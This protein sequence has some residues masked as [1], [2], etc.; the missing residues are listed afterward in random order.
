MADD[1]LLSFSTLAKE[2]YGIVLVTGPTGSGKSTT[3]K[4]TLEHIIDG[5]KKIITVEDPVEYNITGITQVQTK[6]EIGYTFATALRSILRQDPDTIMIGEIR[7]IE[8]AEIAVQASLTGHMVFSTLHTNDSLSAFTRLIDM[9]VEPFLV[10]S[11]IRSVLAQRLARQVCDNCK[12]SFAPAKPIIRKYDILRERF[13]NLTVHS[14]EWASGKGCVSC[15]NTGYKGRM[16]LYEIALVSNEIS[17]LI[18][19]NRP[20]HELMEAAK[21]QKYRTLLED[22]L[23]KAAIGETSIEEVMRVT[24]Q[25]DIDNQ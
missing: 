2:P 6:S 19:E 17:D 10:A 21:K 14:P 16:G 1:H 18:M 13:S 4:A 7:D 22:G 11:S 15:Q 12:T 23:M 8:T 9:G 25:G 3:L 5:K 24:G 20:V